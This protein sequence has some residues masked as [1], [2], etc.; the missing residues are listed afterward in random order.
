[1]SDLYC[2]AAP[3][4]SGALIPSVAHIREEAR[5]AILSEQLLYLLDHTGKCPAGCPDCARMKRVEEVLL[6]PFNVKVY[7]G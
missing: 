6:Q 1:M 5:A 3:A 4:P 7:V 2:H